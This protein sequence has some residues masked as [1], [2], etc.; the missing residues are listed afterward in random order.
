MNEQIKEVMQELKETAQA[1]SDAWEFNEYIIEQGDLLE[2]MPKELMTPDA[3]IAGCVSTVYVYG[4]L[5]DGR[6]RYNVYSDAQIV[7]GL[8]ALFV[9][10]LDGLT[11]QEVLNCPDEVLEAIAG[12]ASLTPS[13]MN[14]L[15]AAFMQ[16][17]GIATKYKNK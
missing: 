5:N 15:H 14:G 7:K 13:R 8:L 1:A 11:P 6:M 9:R 3:K 12:K 10:M 2:E 4:E 17:Q 16:M